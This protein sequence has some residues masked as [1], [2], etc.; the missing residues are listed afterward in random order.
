M[1][2][3]YSPS[4]FEPALKRSIVRCIK[5]I[6]SFSLPVV[7][8][9]SENK[10]ADITFHMLPHATLLSAF[11]DLKLRSITASRIFRISPFN[12]NNQAEIWSSCPVTFSFVEMTS[13]HLCKGKGDWEAQSVFSLIIC[14][15]KFLCAP[16]ICDACFPYWQ[17]LCM[18]PG[19]F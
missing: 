11:S 12:S 17:F 18:P 9:T 8:S 16:L 1:R 7:V 15:R 14:S 3:I 5:V 6:L 2:I 10:L 4:F 19:F 13:S